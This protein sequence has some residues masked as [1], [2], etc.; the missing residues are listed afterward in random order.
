[1]SAL[2]EQ[3]AQPEYVLCPGEGGAFFNVQVSADGRIVAVL[4]R[5]A[6]EVR[7]WDTETGEQIA[8]LD[9]P[10]G[11]SLEYLTPDGKTIFTAARGEIQRW[12]IETQLPVGPP[13]AIPEEAF[14]DGERAVRAVSPDG[15]W[16]FILASA[17]RSSVEPGLVDLE[18]GSIHYPFG[19]SQSG[20]S[21]VTPRFSPDGRRLAF[22]SWDHPN[23]PWDGSEV[24]LVPWGER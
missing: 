20:I 10:V 7:V 12:D 23:M 17:Q 9:V 24:H 8:R 15:R 14:E 18:T 5:S 22:T 21:F 2:S 16:A 11:H 4:E 19:Q 1:M 3:L 6:G 13:K